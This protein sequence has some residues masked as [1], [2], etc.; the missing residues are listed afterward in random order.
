L[1]RTG[2][3]TPTEGDQLRRLAEKRNELIQGELQVRVSKAKVERFAR[4]LDTMLKW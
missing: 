1:R 3:L 4:V 2:Y